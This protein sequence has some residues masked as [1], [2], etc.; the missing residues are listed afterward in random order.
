MAALEDILE[1][2]EL[3]QTVQKHIENLWMAAPL[4]A[5][6]SSSAV[7]WLKLADRPPMKPVSGLHRFHQN[8]CSQQFHH[9]FQIVGKHMQAH[10]RT[11]PIQSLGQEMGASHP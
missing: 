9:S 10:F 4:R 11:D 3:A 1:G 7:G 6:P 5:W 2:L 8:S